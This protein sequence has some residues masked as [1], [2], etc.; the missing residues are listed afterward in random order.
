MVKKYLL[1]FLGMALVTYL[2][3]FLPLFILAKKKI[4]RR[5]IVWLSYVPAAVL[6]ALLFPGL[7][8]REGRIDISLNNH[9]LLAA[10]PTFA[11]ALRTR[12]MIF[13]IITGM[14]SILLLN[15]C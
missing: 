9:Y 6:A 14:V 2:P 4:P 8:L 10:L 7:L 5:L 12:N 11:V 13:T 1:L 15:V 3:R